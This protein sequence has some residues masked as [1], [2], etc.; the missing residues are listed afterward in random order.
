MHLMSRPSMRRS[1]LVVLATLAAHAL[2]IHALEARSFVRRQGH[3][4]KRQRRALRELW[5]AYG[6]DVPWNRTIDDV[7][8]LHIATYGPTREP[9]PGSGTRIWIATASWTTSP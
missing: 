9:R 4:T 7:Q 1:S 3:C 6:V 2:H 8:Q 5:P